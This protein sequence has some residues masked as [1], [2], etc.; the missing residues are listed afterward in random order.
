MNPLDQSV[1]LDCP[2]ILPRSGETLQPTSEA[3][4]ARGEFHSQR[5]ARDWDEQEEVR[6]YWEEEKKIIR[7][8]EHGR[9]SI[10]APQVSLHDVPN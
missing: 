5:C 9:E 4:V 6:L 7:V 3:A 1:F 2:L 10:P 8:P